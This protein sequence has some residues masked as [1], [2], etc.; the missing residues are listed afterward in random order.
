MLR[1]S[2][3]SL[4]L[5]C[6]WMMNNVITMAQSEFVFID[7]V[8]PGMNATE[9][10]AETVN[11]GWI[12][13]VE[14][15]YDYVQVGPAWTSAT[16]VSNLYFPPK[17][18]GNASAAAGAGPVNQPACNSIS[19]LN[20]G[21]AFAPIYIDYYAV[22]YNVGVTRARKGWEVVDVTPQTS[23]PTGCLGVDVTFTIGGQSDGL[24]DFGGGIWKTEKGQNPLTDGVWLADIFAGTG[25][26]GQVDN[27]DVYGPG[28]LV[29]SVNSG[30]SVFLGQ[31]E[32]TFHERFPQ[33]QPGDVIWF[34][35][36][37]RGDGLPY[38]HAGFGQEIHHDYVNYGSPP[39]LSESAGIV[40]YEF[41]V[42]LVASN[43]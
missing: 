43:P 36:A 34:M 26:L 11:E 2:K 6:S 29:N 4:M 32:H 40:D 41:D 1:A 21:I 7:E 18:G 28:L 12:D 17:A 25:Y 15:D 20:Q 5:A 16:A 30:I 22:M 27:T 8:L 3:L 31:G 39:A 35:G 24:W 10:F 14:Y 38:P 23:T 9:Y 33:V 42:S 13:D 37:D 19:M